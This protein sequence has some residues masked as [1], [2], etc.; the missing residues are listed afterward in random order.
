MKYLIV[1]WFAVIW[2]LTLY[3]D[4]LMYINSH[5]FT[6]NLHQLSLS[7]FG[8]FQWCN[9]LLHVRFV[10]CTLKFQFMM[11]IV[12]RY[13]LLVGFVYILIVNFVTSFAGVRT[14]EAICTWSLSHF[15]GLWGRHLILH[16]LVHFLRQTYVW[17]RYV[18][19]LWLPD[20][21][22]VRL[23]FKCICIPLTEFGH[24]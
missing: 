5:V 24:W 21:L 8:D 17:C 11:F 19:C 10:N 6:Y 7:I 13:N 23:G 15:L 4:T 9:I 14:L 3:I 22:I 18:F 1:W 16:Q 12:S 20:T 2:H